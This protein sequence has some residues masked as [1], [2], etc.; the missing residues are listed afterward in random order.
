MPSAASAARRA[1]IAA[2]GFSILAA[3]D[4]VSVRICSSAPGSR[5]ADRQQRCDGLGD[6]GVEL[7]ARRR[8]KPGS[9]P[10]DDLLAGARAQRRVGPLSSSASMAGRSSAC[11]SPCS[12]SMARS[13]SLAAPATSAPAAHRNS[14]LRQKWRFRRPA[15]AAERP[16]HRP[17]WRTGRDRRLMSNFARPAARN[18]STESAS[19]SARRRRGR[20]GPAVPRRPE[21]TVS[22]RRAGAMA[23]RRAVIAK[24]RR[25][26]SP[27]LRLPCRQ[28]GMV[29]SGRRQIRG[30]KDR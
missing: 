12:A 14:R 27:A 19:I 18:A 17:A 29:R 6:L 23:E 2:S 10:F 21:K 3:T 16:A 13:A 26:G 5:P 4:P 24:P 11:L 28:I 25:K 15:I 22:A 1:S 20:Q 7:R 30:P 8:P 9:Q